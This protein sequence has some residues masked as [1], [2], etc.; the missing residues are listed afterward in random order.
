MTRGARR[1]GGRIAWV[2]YEHLCDRHAGGVL[3]AF[4]VGVEPKGLVRGPLPAER[5]DPRQR[6]VDV[7]LEHQFGGDACINTVLYGVVLSL[8][9]NLDPADPQASVLLEALWRRAQSAGAADRTHPDL[10]LPTRPMRTGDA[11][12]PP[13]LLAVHEAI[14]GAT[15]APVRGWE[16]LL[17]LGPARGDW[18]AGRTGTVFAVGEDGFASPAGARPLSPRD[19]GP[20]RAPRLWLLWEN[21]D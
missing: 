14:G 6:R 5:R 13:E 19:L 11:M 8:R 1:S 20:L 7:A 16:A 21:C 4:V 18:L 3:P 12:T 2:A 9:D 15:P 17:D 10:R